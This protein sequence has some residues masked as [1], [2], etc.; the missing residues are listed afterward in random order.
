[1][2]YALK[3]TTTKQGALSL[4]PEEKVYV[5]LCC[6]YQ[7]SFFSIRIWTWSPTPTP[8]LT[9]TA[10]TTLGPYRST[11]RS[12]TGIRCTS[13]AFARQPEKWRLSAKRTTTSMSSTTSSTSN[14]AS[15]SMLCSAPLPPPMTSPLSRRFLLSTSHLEGW[16]SEEL[17]E[18][19]T[20]E[21]ITITIRSPG[22]MWQWCQIWLRVWRAWSKAEG[23]RTLAW[24][25]S[26][27]ITI[28]F[29]DLEKNER[30]SGWGWRLKGGGGETFHVFF[31]LLLLLLLLLFLFSFF[32]QLF[33]LF[34]F[35]YKNYFQK[36]K[37]SN[38]MAVITET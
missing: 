14:S 4:K 1:M 19:W 38:L 22:M 21:A 9:R 8:T 7:V 29:D 3:Q 20:K 18:E 26:L 16:E 5:L 23:S 6:F 2:H 34:S 13:L 12:W 35:N 32:F 17:E 10:C 15:S 27:R 24:S 28:R 11:R 25:L 31:L 30:L 33:F 37:L 36:K